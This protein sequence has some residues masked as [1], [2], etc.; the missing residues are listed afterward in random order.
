[1]KLLII[2]QNP[3]NRG[4][5]AAGKALLRALGEIRNIQQIDI[6]YKTVNTLEDEKLT[7]VTE[8]DVKH[9]PSVIPSF[10]DKAL[11]I[12]SF[13][14][15]L[16]LVRVLLKISP[17]KRQY[18]L[19]ED[20]DVIV[21]ASGGVNIGPYKDWGYLWRLYI[22]LKLNKPLAVYSISFG[23]IP[24]NKLYKSVSL[25]VLRKVGFLSLR[26]EQSQAYAKEYDIKHIPSIDTAFLDSKFSKELPVE[27]N[28][29]K[30]RKY[31]VVVPNALY[32][33]HPYY[34]NINTE[35][36]DKIYLEIINFFTNKG[37]RVIL[38]PQLFGSQ[39]DSKYFIKLCKNLP[40]NQDVELVSDNYSCDIQQSIINNAEFLVGAR[41]HS[42][43][44]AIRGEIPFIALSYEHKMEYMLS[45]LSLD[46]Y[47]V[48][49]EGNLLQ[50]SSSQI[51]KKIEDSFA[52]REMIK[53]EL[54]LANK[55]SKNIA[56]KTFLSLKAFLEDI[57]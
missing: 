49:L 5:E 35:S 6:L 44:F 29:I 25:Y 8:Q 12:L 4:D 38:L 13:F 54:S 43:V 45:S 23:P 52:N 42:I 37:I 10:F 21:S 28:G 16:S 40:N 36:L 14:L 3:G 31:V 9:H 26:D 32:L 55:K 33:W 24:N 27:L 19:I 2:N 7:I 11:I 50:G 22:S 34:K 15:P 1:M 30:Q 48:V 20:A 39:N 18:K 47:A 51:V 53:Q 46:K 56:R 41:Y 57:V 17:L